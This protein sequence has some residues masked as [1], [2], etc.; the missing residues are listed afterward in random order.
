LQIVDVAK[1]AN[2]EATTPKLV[3]LLNSALHVFNE[4]SESVTKK[5][6]KK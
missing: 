3:K 4:S 1:V 2:I 6:G 5:K